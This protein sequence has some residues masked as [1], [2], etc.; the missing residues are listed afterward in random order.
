MSSF[1]HLRQCRCCRRLLLRCH[2]CPSAAGYFQM[3]SYHSC[4]RSHL[5]PNQTAEGCIPAGSCPRTRNI[6]MPTQRMWIF[7]PKSTSEPQSHPLIYDVIII[8]IWIA[9]ISPS[10]VVQVFLSRVWKHGA[11]ILQ[12][13]KTHMSKIASTQNNSVQFYTLLPFDSDRWRSACR[14]IRC[15]A[16]H[17][18][19]SLRHTGNHR[20][21]TRRHTHTWT[22]PQMPSPGTHTLH[23]CGNCVFCLCTD[24]MVHTP[25]AKALINVWSVERKENC[26]SN[27]TE[28]TCLVLRASSSPRPNGWVPLYRGGQGRQ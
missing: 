11:V 5:C 2:R 10:V 22:K 13:I 15:W 19:Q 21:Q 23:T 28:H 4:P 6:F 26:Y 27:K 9:R 17:P 8:I 12:P 1:Y 7:T 24:C 25:S 20:P 16:N 3:G 14:V 18:D